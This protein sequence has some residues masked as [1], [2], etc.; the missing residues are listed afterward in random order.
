MLPKRDLIYQTYVSLLRIHEPHSDSRLQ[1]GDQDERKS[2]QLLH[3]PQPEL[4]CLVLEEIVDYLQKQ[5][6]SG[7][8]SHHQC[9]NRVELVLRSSTR[10]R[11]SSTQSTHNPHQ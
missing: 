1:A 3:L 6:I 10:I 2:I 9:Y 11:D 5:H 8:Q 7:I 4:G